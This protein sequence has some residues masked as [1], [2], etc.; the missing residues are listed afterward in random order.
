M[1]V[2]ELVEWHVFVL[3]LIINVIHVNMGDV[4]S[5]VVVDVVDVVDVD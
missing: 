4:E 5:E 3:V 1:N 2:E